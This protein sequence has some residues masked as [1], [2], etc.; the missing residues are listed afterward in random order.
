M[1][2]FRTHA[3]HYRKCHVRPVLRRIDMDAARR[4]CEESCRCRAGCMATNLP[5][6]SETVG[7]AGA[8]RTARSGIQRGHRNRQILARD[9]HCARSDRERMETWALVER[10]LTL[11]CKEIRYRFRWMLVRVKAKKEGLTA[12]STTTGK[13]CAPLTFFKSPACSIPCTG[14][15]GRPVAGNTG[16]A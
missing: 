12:E 15:T 3:V 9:R 14:K 1:Q 6:V 7:H 2:H 4:G 8:T 11:H 16:S 10:V 13:N 5:V